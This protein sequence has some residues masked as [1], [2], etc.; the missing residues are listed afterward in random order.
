MDSIPKISITDDRLKELC[1]PWKDALILTLLGRP[2]NLNM[3]RDRV[4]WMLKSDNFELIDLPNNFFV[5]RSTEKSLSNKLLFEGPWAIQ[6]HYLAVQ[7]WSPNFNPYSNKKSKVAIWIRVPTLP[8][9]MYTEEF[10]LELGNMVGKALK[11]D[12]NTLAQRD[13]KVNEVARAKFAR[14]S[15]EVDLNKQ[16]KSKFMIRTQLYIVE[17]EGLNTICFRCGTYG[18]SQEQ[19][20]HEKLPKNQQENSK[21][22]PASPNLSTESMGTPPPEGDVTPQPS[23]LMSFRGKCGISLWR[24]DES[25]AF[26]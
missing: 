26:P 9:H 10:M 25:Q 8:V 13:N 5:F 16:L 4:A 24:M 12:L 22:D 23:P 11:V 3:M 6:G 2:T 18:H 17:Y 15:V 14:V 19:C 1:R 20:G 7:R 21:Q